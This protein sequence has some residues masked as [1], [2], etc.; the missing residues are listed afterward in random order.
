MNTMISVLAIL[1]LLI[2]RTKGINENEAHKSFRKLSQL[3]NAQW[4]TSDTFILPGDYSMAAAYWNNSIYLLGG[5]FDSNALIIMDLNYQNTFYNTTALDHPHKSTV[6]A[7]MQ[8]QDSSHVYY[9]D[10]SAGFRIIKY[11]LQSKSEIGYVTASRQQQQIDE[12]TCVTL[13]NN[14]LYL[15]GGGGEANPSATVQAY[16]LIQEIFINF[17][18][19]MQIKRISHACEFDPIEHQ[20]WIIGGYGGTDFDTLDSVEKKSTDAITTKNWDFSEPLLIPKKT[21]SSIY[22]NQYIMVMGGWDAG[23][24]N[25]VVQIINCVTGQVFFGGPLQ[26][27]VEYAASILIYDRVHLFGGINT[28]T[29]I[30]Y[31]DISM[32]YLRS[33]EPTHTTEF[34]TPEP[35]DTDWINAGTILPRADVAMAVAYLNEVF[36]LFGGSSNP[37]QL[38]ITNQYGDMYDEGINALNRTLVSPVQCYIQYHQYLFYIPFDASGQVPIVAYNIE[39]MTGFPWDVP[40]E[41]IDFQTCVAVGNDTLYLIGGLNLDVVATVQAYNLLDGT[42][43][44]PVP[45]MQISRKEH[46]CEFDPIKQMLWVIGGQ[47]VNDVLK[48]VENIYTNSITTREWKLSDNLLVEVTAMSTIYYKQYIFV[49][50]GWNNNWGAINDVQIINCATGQVFMAGSLNYPVYSAASILVGDRVYLFAGSNDINLD[51][52]QY[53]TVSLNY[54]QS[55]EPSSSPTQQSYE[56]SSSTTNNK[57]VTIFVPIVV[58]V[59]LIAIII[60]VYYVVKKRKSNEN[61]EYEK[62]DQKELIE[63][64]KEKKTK[65]ESS[66]NTNEA[67]QPKNMV[68]GNEPNENVSLLATKIEEKKQDVIEP[69]NE[70]DTIRT[71]A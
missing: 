25:S 14:V 56:P 7:Y 31:L 1:L 65:L 71:N 64:D 53:L 27:G 59:L 3:N 5:H 13:G 11:D 52:H 70:T 22:Y 45:Y 69:P 48:S 20:L 4:N 37:S 17:I 32:D 44:N 15:T 42:W 63:M 12:N 62:V 9:I 19:D 21:M 18:P 49:M 38:V 29:D 28:Y 60:I 54:I 8:M 43:I 2:N 26:Y 36:Y 24:S 6:H 61:T 40:P 58:I 34:P 23:E 30:Q 41:P 46:A 16:D 57:W 39:V 67:R 50:G 51:T 66:T 10:Y 33:F 55:Y 35:A 68:E 47:N